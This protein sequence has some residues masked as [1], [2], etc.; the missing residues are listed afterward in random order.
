MK[1]KIPRLAATIS[2]CQYTGSE[3]FYEGY[4]TTTRQIAFIAKLSLY[5]SWT[6]FRMR[7]ISI[8]SD[9]PVLKSRQ[10]PPKTDQYTIYSIEGE[11]FL[12][13]RRRKCFLYAFSLLDSHQDS[14]QDLF[15]CTGI[16]LRETDL[17]FVCQWIHRQIKFL[18]RQFFNSYVY[19]AVKCDFLNFFHFS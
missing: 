19:Y 5:K 11:I 14:V 13:L 12:F 2:T 15:F 9:K 3:I 4:S 18:P 8:R 10:P 1:W 6:I 17:L 7:L 16:W